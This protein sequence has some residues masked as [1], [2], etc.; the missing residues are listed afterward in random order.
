MRV[1]DDVLDGMGMQEDGGG[2]SPLPR[3]GVPP[4]LLAGLGVWLSCSIAWP[5]APFFGGSRLLAVAA[6]SAAISAV[7]LII[8]LILRTKIFALTL[9]CAVA[10]GV[11]ASSVSAL[12]MI[13]RA[14]GALEHSGQSAV[15]IAEEDASLS[16]Y[17]SSASATIVFGDGFRIPVLAYFDD[18]VVPPLYGQAFT[19][20]VELDEAS[21]RSLDRLWAKGRMLTATFDDMEPFHR[22]GVLGFLVSLRSSALN[23]IG[24][25]DDASAV[26]KALA[27]GYT[28]DYEGTA[29]EH[30]FTVTGLA[31]V[32]AVSGAHLVIIGSF[33][34]SLLRALRLPKGARLAISILAMLAYLVLAGMPVSGIRALIMTCASQ[35]AF[36]ARRRST[37]LSTL[38]GCVF[39]M[40]LF[41][42]CIAVS[43]SFCLSALSTLGIALFG[44]L[45]SRWTEKLLPF[46][47]RALNEAAALTLSAGILAQPYAC[48]LF[49]Q[50]PVVS[51]LAN[52]AAAPF[53]APACTLGIIC[54]LVATVLP[55]LADAIL[56]PAKVCV[57]LLCI[58]VA[59]CAR[60]PLAS[61]PVSTEPA[62]AVLASFVAAFLL[63]LAWPAPPKRLRYG[64]LAAKAVCLLAVLALF[65]VVAPILRGDRL[66]MLDVGQGDAFL[67]SSGG[68]SILIDT[69]MQDGML[70]SA[71]ARQGVAHLNAVAITHADA[72]HCGSLAGLKGTV[73]VDRVLMARDALCCPCENCSQLRSDAVEL[74]GV[75][76]IAPL[77][78]GDLLHVGAFALETLWP[79]CYQ[80]EGGNADSLCFLLTYDNFSTKSL[81]P[82]TDSDSAQA[83]SPGANFGSRSARSG[84]SPR[85]LFTGDAE[86]EQLEQIM[87]TTGLSDIE[88]L[89]VGH[90]GS[91]NSLAEDQAERLSPEISLVSV[92]EDNRYG[93]PA[94]AIIEALEDTGSRV[95][96]TD[97]SG[98]VSCRF[99][100]GAIEVC[101]LR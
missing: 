82:Q 88:I 83:D 44:R 58:C 32:V 11:A 22:G 97:E 20:D 36:L 60:L 84:R 74:V 61:V 45:F 68:A 55:G 6:G 62:V 67:V 26:L 85:A 80:Q 1:K 43:A 100:P 49:N 70:R 87:Q 63:W 29:A 77:S 71:L 16:L 25:A 96:R 40:V 3:P 34:G 2:E 69:G 51:V 65:N 33:L 15:L 18:D 27:C 57:E 41:Q 86:S 12:S 98:D 21:D 89:K 52:M 73:A 46:V 4:L 37:G 92:G 24:G 54:T 91:I 59:W 19:A 75:E 8:I 10:L 78:Q 38:G 50:L 56:F 5:H 23:A 66:V 35:A 81:G 48:G 42:P 14:D 90:H 72:D 53:V 95:L 79:R 28:V 101:T 93:H 31:H 47:P 99:S 39:A 76:G 9:T 7:T 94:K 30:H 17:G 13:E 64:R